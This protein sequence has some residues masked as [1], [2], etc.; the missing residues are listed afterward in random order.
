MTFVLTVWSGMTLSRIFAES[1]CRISVLVTL[2]LLPE[3]VKCGLVMNTI[4]TIASNR[5]II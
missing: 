2:N 3:C 4:T 1:S 5:I